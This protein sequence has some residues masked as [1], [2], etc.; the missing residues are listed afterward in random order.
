MLQSHACDR[1]QCDSAAKIARTATQH[2]ITVAQ[3][4][5]MQQQVAAG[6]SAIDKSRTDDSASLN[7]S[8]ISFLF[9]L[10]TLAWV[11]KAVASAL[12]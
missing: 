8:A 11:R 4:P 5:N 6:I 1:S 10:M 12:S 7:H 2:S 9:F 3:R